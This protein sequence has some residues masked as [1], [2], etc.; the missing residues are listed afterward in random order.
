MLRR[1]SLW[2]V[3]LASLFLTAMPA[4]AQGP[5]GADL[6]ELY[7]KV[8]KDA[9][10][11][12]APAVVQIQT[13]GGSD[14]V[15]TGPKGPA[16]RKALGPT[17]G[18]IVSADGYIVSSAFNFINN[19]T[20]IVIG[21]AGHKEPYLAKRIATD[22]SRML[23]LLKIEA[24]GLPVAAAAPKKTVQVGQTAV[25]LGRTLDTNRNNPPSVSVGIISAIGR[26]WGKAFQTDCKISP[27]NYGGPLLDIEGRV[28][29]ILIPASPQSED[30]TAGYEWY[31]SGIGFA[32]PMEDVFAVLPRL[33]EGKDL[34]KGLLGVR[35]QSPD[36]YSVA[37]S[38]GEV[39]PGS[40]A[41]KAGLKVGD[42]ITEIDGHGISRLAQIMHLLGPKY[43]GDTI[44][45]K[46]R[47]GKDVVTV[48]QLQLVGALS[49]F[50]HASLGILPVRDDPKLGVEVRYVFAKSAAEKAGLKAGDRIVKYGKGAALQAFKG[51]KRGRLEL[52]EFLN[53]ERPGEEIKLEVVHKDGGKTETVSLKLDSLAEAV[54]DGVPAK[55]PEP[56]TRGKAL[57]PLEPA[58]AAKADAPPKKAETGLLKRKN[59]AGDRTYWVYVDDDYDP[60]I[61]HALV[62]WLHPPKQ[63]KK[64][65]FEDFTETWSDFC[66]ENHIIMVCPQSDNDGGW[67]PGDAD[68]VQ[69]AVR[70]VL[71]NYTIDRQRIVAHGLGV[72]GQMALYLG[73]H[74]RDL[75][76]GVATTGAVVT[77]AK[78]N[79]AGQRVAFYL[80]AGGR[81]PLVK[82][83]AESQTKLVERGF[84]VV[85]REIATMGRQYLNEQQLA[86]LVRWIDSLD[87]L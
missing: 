5:D 49:V 82:A 67:V 84:P 66:R 28:Q 57:D 56:A 17:T 43:E 86:E 50:T 58:K 63:N 14:M 3:V 87:R 23:T 37:P 52:T 10:K 74:S 46:Y 68:F 61:A 42:V 32:V 70:G 24:A 69:E 15:V 22:R 79:L 65:S 4:T 72:G 29:G 55:L 83:I 35:L 31:D 16:F 30:E 2:T 12:V 20:T 18:V 9:V 25:A 27:V 62:I 81:D 59:G 41:A 60:A 80:V 85:Y 44:A 1:A 64:E 54:K 38:V 73:F 11:K 21:V 33:K 34:K 7:E 19:P 75:I 51:E 76:R 53:K 13:Q 45:L 77:Q 48:A 6:N 71:A 39:T 47:R 40:A 78:D 26:I 8:I 36:I